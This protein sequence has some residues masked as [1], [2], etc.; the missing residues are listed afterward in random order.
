MPRW[1]Q[2]EKCPTCGYDIATGEGERGC[3]YGDCPY[4]PEELNVFCDDCRF[5]FFTGEGNPPCDDPMTCANGAAAREHV[6]NVKHW[7]DLHGVVG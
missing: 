4:L 7:R 3:Q 5:D 1:E 2:F 6:A